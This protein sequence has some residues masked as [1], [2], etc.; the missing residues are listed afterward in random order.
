MQAFEDINNVFRNSQS[1]LAEAVTFK[2][3]SSSIGTTINVNF[4]N[5]AS[6]N[7]M[8]EISITKK[9][10]TAYCNTN[11]ITGA[12]QASRII[13]NGIT[14]YI[15]KIDPDEDAETVLYLSKNQIL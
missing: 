7:Q 11:D 3:T 10:P 4:F 5:E 9:E 12:T 15:A 1:E 2:L 6:E 13:R 14:Y 8:G